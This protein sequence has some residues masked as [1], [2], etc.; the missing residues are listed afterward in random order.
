MP[1]R[2]TGTLPPGGVIIAGN[3]PTILDGMVVG[4]FTPRRVRFLIYAEMFRL[5]LIGRWLRALGFL[6]AGNLDEAVECLRRGECLGIFPE[7]HNTHSYDLREFKRGVAVLAQ[8][9]GCPVV[10]FGLRGTEELCPGD[11]RYVRGGPLALSFGTPLFVSDVDAGR[12]Q[13]RAA[14]GQELSSMARPAGPFTRAWALVV[15]PVTWLLL[16]LADMGGFQGRR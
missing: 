14:V 8:R 13:V 6:P 5:P 9:S 15:M 1:A 16:R 3:H 10:P 11:A 12:D 7:G 4:T 2:V